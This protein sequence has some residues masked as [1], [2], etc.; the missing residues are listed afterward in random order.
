MKG[1]KDV[2]SGFNC[3]NRL[4]CLFAHDWKNW[5]NERPVERRHRMIDRYLAK[6]HRIILATQTTHAVSTQQT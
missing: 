6:W 4:N 1:L 5:E 2:Y 3:D